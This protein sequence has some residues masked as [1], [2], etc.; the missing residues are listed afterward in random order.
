M[1]F[2]NDNTEPNLEQNS[3]GAEYGKSRK[4]LDSCEHIFEI[5]FLFRLGQFSIYNSN[6]CVAH[7][8]AHHIKNLKYGRIFLLM[9]NSY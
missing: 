7:R 9:D 6:N 8:S 2:E 5:C 1:S 4:M 3:S